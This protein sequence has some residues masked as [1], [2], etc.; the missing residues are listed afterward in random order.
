MNLRSICYMKIHSHMKIK[1]CA[2][3]LICTFCHDLSSSILDVR[4]DGAVSRCQAS[5]IQRSK[6]HG[7]ESHRCHRVRA[8]GRR[9]VQVRPVRP[10]INHFQ[11]IGLC[12]TPYVYYHI[13]TQLCILL[14]GYFIII[15]HL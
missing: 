3:R 4:P 12:I 8:Y 10:K 5:I 1:R 2:T 15:I 9:Y 14:N 13:L 6:S 11:Y 7:L